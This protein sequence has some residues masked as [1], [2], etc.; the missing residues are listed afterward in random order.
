MRD[1]VA[2]GRR[3]GRLLLASR[4]R[5]AMPRRDCA[6]FHREMMTPSF[7]DLS[8]ARRSLPAGRVGEFP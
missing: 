7:D 5:P 8:R 2:A 1:D 3:F 6:S 4:R